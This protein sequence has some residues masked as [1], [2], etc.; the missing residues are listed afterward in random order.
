MYREFKISL[1]SSVPKM[2][3]ICDMGLVVIQITF[4]EGQQTMLTK[5]AMDQCGALY[6]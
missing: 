4:V 2:A 5:G 3:D 6:E 1:S